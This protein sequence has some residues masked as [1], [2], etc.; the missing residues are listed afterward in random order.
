M[1]NPPRSQAIAESGPQ[2]RIEQDHLD[3]AFECLEHELVTADAE[4]KATN[5][6]HSVTTPQGRSERDAKAKHHQQRLAKLG[7]VSGQLCFGRLDFNDAEPIHIGRIGLSD[8]DRNTILVDWRAEAASAFYRATPLEP[9][10]VNRRRH[11]TTRNRNVTG[12]DD[13]LLD[14]DLSDD[15]RSTLVGE[16]ALL[17]ALNEHRTG[18]MGNIVATIQSEQDQIIRAPLRGTLVVQ[19]GPGTGKTVVAL[20]R[21]A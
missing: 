2:V 17:A 13:D 6:D 16:A 3:T 8:H 21:A 1:P 14:N 11:I 5:A 10:G 18:R 7:S 19:G 4:L 20:H 12:I 15:Q 9:L